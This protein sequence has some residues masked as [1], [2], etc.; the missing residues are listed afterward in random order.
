MIS[1]LM[2]IIPWIFGIIV[3][4]VALHLC[5]WMLH[6]L[7]CYGKCIPRQSDTADA[8][9]A[10]YTTKQDAPEYDVMT[11]EYDAAVAATGGNVLSPSSSSKTIVEKRSID[12]NEAIAILSKT[13]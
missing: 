4:M 3:A 7:L 10:L 12:I 8:D 11:T 2:K 9:N 6:N 5:L 1:L 13:K